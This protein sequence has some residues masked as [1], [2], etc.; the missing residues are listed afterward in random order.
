M[1][2]WTYLN[3][4]NLISSL[5]SC[6]CRW[7]AVGEYNQ[8]TLNALFQLY[9]H[10]LTSTDIF[11]FR[12]LRPSPILYPSLQGDNVICT[13]SVSKTYVI[14]SEYLI[15]LYDLKREPHTAMLKTHSLKLCQV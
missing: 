9:D 15:L 12:I 11:T 5:Q 10:P 13:D 8:E 14:L 4:Y 1:S 2:G 7:R 6:S 3:I